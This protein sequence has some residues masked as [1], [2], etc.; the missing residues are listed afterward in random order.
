MSLICYLF[1]LELLENPMLKEQN[2]KI[3][4]KNIRN[5]V[6]GHTLLSEYDTVIC[7]DTMKIIQSI[8]S[9]NDIPP[10][11]YNG[12]L[13]VLFVIVYPNVTS[14]E[15]EGTLVNEIVQNSFKQ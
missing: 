6:E 11:Q 7:I 8:L 15:I 14:E 13:N 9:K 5:F 2:A 10:E 1:Q 3:N 12:V 4:V